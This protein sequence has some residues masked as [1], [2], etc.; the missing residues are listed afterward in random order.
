MTI[1]KLIGIA[2]TL[3]TLILVAKDIFDFFANKFRKAEK[4]FIL[5]RDKPKHASRARGE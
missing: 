3:L 4:P 5:D 2:V 1:I